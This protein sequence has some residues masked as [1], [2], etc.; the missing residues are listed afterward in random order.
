MHI[1]T[2][3]LTC[4]LY[5]KKF[6]CS[7]P[8]ALTHFSNQKHITLLLVKLLQISSPISRKISSFTQC[9]LLCYPTSV[10]PLHP[11]P[12]ELSIWFP[13]LVGLRFFQHKITCMMRSVDDLEKALDLFHESG[14]GWILGHLFPKFTCPYSLIY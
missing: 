13:Q 3:Q 14:S 8:Y 1:N 4:Y 5:Q 10:F 9:A 7:E 12:S 6:F 11:T 2:L